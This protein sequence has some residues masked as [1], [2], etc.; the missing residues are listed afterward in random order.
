[1]AGAARP[2]GQELVR[3]EDTVV[4]LFSLQ[5][6]REVDAKVLRRIEQRLD[7]NRKARLE[8]TDRLQKLYSDL[9]D[10]FDRYRAALHRPPGQSSPGGQDREADSEPGIQ[11]IEDQIEV[12]QFDVKAAERVEAAVRDEGHKLR[13]DL[14]D[15]KERMALLDGQIESL[16][17]TLPRPRESVTGIWDITL[18]PSGDKGVFALFQSGTIV[19]GQY[20]LDGPFQG[21]LDGTLIDRKLLMHRIDSR[22][23]RSMDLSAFLS[24][25]G[26]ALR[27]SWENYDLSNGQARSGSW[28]ARRRPARRTPQPAGE[29]QTPQREG[30]PP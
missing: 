18:M 21:S 20:V 10:L 16:H 24:Q 1:M 9:D 23:G 17:A 19:S 29:E 3:S 2:T 26:Q 11:Q 13:D 4:A 5:M 25:D 12:M 8:A 27:G 15:L 7:E 14:R 22:L 6:E 28:S 30:S